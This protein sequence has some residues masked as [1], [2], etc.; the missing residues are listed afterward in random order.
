MYL[1]AHLA[2]VSGF[3]Q[4][5]E[6][7]RNFEVFFGGEVWRCGVFLFICLFGFEVGC[8]L[9]FFFNFKSAGQVGDRNLWRDEVSAKAL[10]IRQPI[11]E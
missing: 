7:P 3:I 8:L 10:N 5:E 1:H 11:W 2:T 6:K 9:G 4:I